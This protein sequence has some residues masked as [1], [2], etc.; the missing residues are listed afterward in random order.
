MPLD[1]GCELFRRQIV[2]RLDFIK[3]DVEGGELEVIRGA[4]Q[5]LKSERPGWLMEVSRS[6]SKEVLQAFHDL[7][8]RA[9]VFNGR[10]T[11]TVNYRDKEFSNYFFFTP[12]QLVGVALRY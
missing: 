8:Y 12:D 1:S 2:T 3:C 10:L 5:L 11:E 7:G 6:T 9:F 4:Q